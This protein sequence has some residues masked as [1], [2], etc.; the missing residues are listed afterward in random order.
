MA[1]DQWKCSQ[2]YYINNNNYHSADFETQRR[3]TTSAKD[4]YKVKHDWQSFNWD[5]TDVELAVYK[6]NFMFVK[7][8]TQ[9]HYVNEFNQV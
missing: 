1:L 4:E 9:L 6:A 8:V 5:V 7:K 3:A 2:S